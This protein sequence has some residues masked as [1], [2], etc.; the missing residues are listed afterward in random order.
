[1]LF[2]YL[3]AS[4]ATEASPDRS[5]SAFRRLKAA[6]REQREMKANLGVLLEGIRAEREKRLPWTVLER[7]LEAIM[8]SR[9]VDVNATEG[10]PGGKKLVPP[11]L[12]MRSDYTQGV[13]NS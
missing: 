5:V 7:E 10:Q 3:C 8:T 6:E 9:P 12:I 13:W 4:E 1:M 2:E 11:F